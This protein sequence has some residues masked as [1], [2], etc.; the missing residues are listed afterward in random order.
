MKKNFLFAMAMAAVFAGC[1][2][3][4]DPVANAGENALKGEGYVSLALS[5]PTTPTTS[6]G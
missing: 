2:S 3:D 4:D 1:S 6:S 5:L